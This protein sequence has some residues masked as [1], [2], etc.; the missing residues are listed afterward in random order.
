MNPWHRAVG[1]AAALYQ[2]SV[3]Q[4]FA[5]YRAPIFGG[6]SMLPQELGICS[7]FTI[8]DLEATRTAE[9]VAA[10][11][12]QLKA[13][14]SEVD[15][16]WQGR[17]FDKA[18]QEEFASLKELVEASQGREAEFVARREYV[19]S[20]AG[21]ES[22][23]ERAGTNL[24]P[25]LSAKSR[26][27]ENVFDLGEYRA[28]TSS[29][30]AQVA[31]MRDGARKAA[32]QAVYPHDNATPDRTVAH[33]HKLLEKIDGGN[34]EVA[35]GA[36]AHRILATGSPAYAR[37]FGKM[38]AGR[39]M[40]LSVEE[41]AAL[42]VVGS[43]Q[44][45][46]GGYAVPYTLDPTIILTSDGSVN[47]LRTISR[48]ETITGNT[49]KGVTS[50]G[51]TV[52]RGAEEAA[53]TDN[54][55]T[56]AQPEVTVQAVKTLIKFSI[57]ADQDWPRLQAE[58]ARILQ[59]AKDDEEASSFVNGVGT[60]VYPGGVVSTLDATSH[61]GTTGDGF[62][63]DDIGVLAGR[64]PDR[65]EPRARFLGHRLIYTEIARL[66]RV[67]GNGSGMYQPLASGRPATL[68]GYPAHNSSAMESDFTTTGNEI[69]LFGDFSTGFLIVDKVGMSVELI[70]HIVNGDGNPTGQRGI[71]AHW[72][73]SSVIL[74]DNAFRLLKVGVV[75]TGI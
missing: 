1:S 12:D 67:N 37:A 49:W 75:T 2:G 45:A 74:V 30:E 62:D 61:V 25:R 72:R 51:I 34:E 4:P 66:D 48:V 31:L 59:D 68:L 57:E 42:A 8:Q 53:V 58:M 64:L 18:T 60:T 52:T 26:I 38:L 27:P 71:F 36:L 44:L 43:S 50:A 35:A 55:P 3:P 39:G 41:R 46:D 69:L 32:E 16:E 19:R 6:G 73:N 40:F 33:I 9:E 23:V 7:L 11:R 24:A 47:P 21:D 63:I 28:R 70:P 5:I 20:L 65:F 56:L 15:S 13:R 10:F 29:I 17:T 22:R 54:S 14:V